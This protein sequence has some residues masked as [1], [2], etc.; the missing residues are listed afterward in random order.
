MIKGIIFDLDGTLLDTLEDLGNSVNSILED[1]G[2][3]TF[4]TE[5][6]KLKVGNGVKKLIERSFPITLKED[7][8]DEALEKFSYYYDK[9]CLEHSKPYPNIVKVLEIL[10]DRGIKVAVNSNKIDA[11]TKDMIAKSFV[12]YPFVSVIGQRIAVATKPDPTSA[13]E[14][15][16]IMAVEADEMLYVGDTEVDLQTAKNAGMKSVA[17]TWGFR[18][19]DAL[20]K[21]EPDYVIDD[22]LEL[23]DLLD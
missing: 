10:K 12:G 5:D 6:Y 22:A 1:Y 9:Y 20:L 3:P 11:Y 17:V 18:P 2:Y 21:A 19:K 4:K 7:M 14:I 16:D 15:R 13:L 23:L 8:M